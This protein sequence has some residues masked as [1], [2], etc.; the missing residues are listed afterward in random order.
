MVSG[1][2]IGQNIIIIVESYIGQLYLFYNLHI[3]FFNIRDD[4]LLDA[5]YFSLVVHLF[6]PTM[7]KYSEM[8][9]SILI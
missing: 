3:H 9:I 4:T 5:P 2:Y 1:P 8:Q 6:Y 7:K